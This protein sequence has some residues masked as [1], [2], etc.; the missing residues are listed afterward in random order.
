MHKNHL[1]LAVIVVM[2]AADEELGSE[3]IIAVQIAAPIGRICP[4][5]SVAL[6]APHP[7]PPRCCVYY[8]PLCA[9]TWPG[10]LFS[11]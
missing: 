7:L 5:I 11:A 4:V 9:F 3:I 8:S 1:M 10:E 2:S 6:A